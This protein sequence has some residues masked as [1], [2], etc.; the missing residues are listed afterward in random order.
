MPVVLYKLMCDDVEYCPRIM[1][2]VDFTFKYQIDLVFCKLC[3]LA[4]PQWSG[5]G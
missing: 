2:E 3:N 4:F 5:C 1:S